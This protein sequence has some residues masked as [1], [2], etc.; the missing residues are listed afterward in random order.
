[1]ILIFPDTEVENS[2]KQA[3]NIRL[4]P[5]FEFYIVL[6]LPYFNIVV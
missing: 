6:L 1:M 2:V 3:R 5:D 4:W